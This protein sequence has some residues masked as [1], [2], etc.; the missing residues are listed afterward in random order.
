[1]ARTRFSTFATGLVAALAVAA[2]PAAAQT[3]EL[4]SS[5]DRALG[6]ELRA[7]QSFEALYASSFEQRIAELADPSQGRIGVA[8]IDLARNFR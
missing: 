6:T 8:A 1:M 5:F 3:D 7:P 4:Q 2:M